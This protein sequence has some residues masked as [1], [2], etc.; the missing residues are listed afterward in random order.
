M[1]PA[2]EEI[3]GRPHLGGIDVGLREHAPTQEH[4]DFLGIDCVVFRFAAMDGVHVEGMPKDEGRAF[5][6]TEVSQPGP[7]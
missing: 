6:G 4:R 5:L 2:P 7:K 3:A 1:Y